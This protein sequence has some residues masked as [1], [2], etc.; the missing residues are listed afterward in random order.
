MQNGSH[1]YGI[2]VS[3]DSSAHTLGRQSRARMMFSSKSVE[4]TVEAMCLKKK[5]KLLF[6][7]RKK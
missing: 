1:G 4:L 7:E 2:E 6:L 3:F 5:K